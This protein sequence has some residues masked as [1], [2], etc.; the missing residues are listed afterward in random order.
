[1]GLPSLL[2]NGGDNSGPGVLVDISDHHSGAL[3][4]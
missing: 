4:D 3:T 2:L 1:M